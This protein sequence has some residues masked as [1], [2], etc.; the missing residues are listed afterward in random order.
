MYSLKIKELIRKKRKEKISM[1]TCY[2][3][4]FAR[5]LDAAGVDTIL[6]GDSL[7]NVIL[8]MDFTR[9]VSFQ[10]MF[11]HTKAVRRGTRK[12][13]LIVDMPYVCYQKDPQKAVYFAK[14]FIEEA[15]AEAVK[16]EWFSGCREV[17][18]NLINNRIPVMGHIG[19]TPQTVQ[20]LGGFRVQGK[21]FEKAFELIKQAEVLEQTGVFSIV[22]ECVPYQ[23]GKLITKSVK[24][25][26]IGIGAGPDCDGQV[27]VLYDLLGLYSDRKPKFVKV[28]ADLSFSITEAVKNFITEVKNKQFPQKEN[29]FSMKDDEFRKLKEKWEGA[30]GMGDEGRGTKR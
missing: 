13:L 26:V 17:T 2:D 18:E 3:Y 19:L 23:L 7:A 22:L 4:S 5:I 20:E 9:E 24:I 8:G 28:Y 11:E 10:E 6:V 16:I 1:L 12:S 15:G 30:R 27:L 14:K 25:P 29:T 21:K